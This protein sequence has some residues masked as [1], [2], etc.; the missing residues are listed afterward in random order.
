MP[1]NE[2]RIFKNK[3]KWADMP[4]ISR[5]DRCVWFRSGY[6]RVMVPLKYVEKYEKEQ[7]DA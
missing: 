5:D 1:I 7:A 4:E 6:G 2:T 3:P